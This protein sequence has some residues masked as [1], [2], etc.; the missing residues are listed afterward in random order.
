MKPELATLIDRLTNPLLMQAS[1]IDWGAPVPSFGDLSTSRVATIGLN[2]SNR[3]FVDAN[4][5]ELHG[6]ERRFHTLNSL[7]ITEWSK[8]D[9]QHLILMLTLCKEYFKRN[10]YDGWFKKLDYVISGAN[11][12]Y[13]FP[14]FD[15]C[16]LD[17]IPYATSCKWT[18]LTSKQR[19]LLL[20]IT[21]DTLGLLLKNS[22]VQLVVLNGQSVVTNFEKITNSSLEQEVMPS[23]TLP[24]KKDPGVTGVAYFGKVSSIGGLSLGREIYVIGYNHNIQ[25]SFGVTHEVLS[26]IRKWVAAIAKDVLA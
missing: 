11:V 25:S 17:L 2:P 20:E 12:S 26:A 21:G 23:W 4:G 16:H 5:K 9:R 15:A 22:H 24:R 10:P 3:E 1:V 18:E 8:V 13:Y 6:E 19:E 14:S 7:G